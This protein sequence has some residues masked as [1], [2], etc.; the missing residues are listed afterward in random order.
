MTTNPYQVLGV[1]EANSDDEIKRAYRE[2]A[3]KYHP[4][5]YGDSP[6]KQVA[7]EKMAEV[8]EAYN[9]IVNQRKARGGFDGKRQS[10]SQQQSYQRAG[11]QAR[12]S[13]PDIRRMIQSNRLVE[14][15]ELLDGTPVSRRD[16][17]WYFLKGTIYYSRGWLED[18]ANHFASA[19]RLDPNN[20]EYRASM[21]RMSWQRQGGFGNSYQNNQNPYR[22]TPNQMGG[23]ST[24]DC[25]S[26]LIC[27]D[28]CCECLGGDLIS[29]C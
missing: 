27:A 21:N 15:E 3:K 2:L 16:A 9:S 13:F 25:C 18:A 12:S 10:Q 5:N 19:C 1:S 24:C 14:A 29:C 8:N 26:S 23:C 20:A 17:E 28:C 4:D 6:L 11:N 22:G 7:E